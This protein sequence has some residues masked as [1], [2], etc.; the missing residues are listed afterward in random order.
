MK[1]LYI[2]I[3]YPNYRNKIDG[4]I[5]AFSD[6]KCDAYLVSFN[7][8]EQMLCLLEYKDSN[9]VVIEALKK[10]WS[11][12]TYAKYTYTILVKYKFD[13]VYIRRL[14]ISVLLFHK[15]TRLI[16]ANKSKLIYEFPTY[17]L[18]CSDNSIRNLIQSIEKKYVMN[19]IIPNAKCIPICCVRNDVKLKPNM[20]KIYNCA[21]ISFYEGLRE[22]KLPHYDGSQLRILAIAHCQKWHAYE[23]L[24][25]A[26]S[27]WN[28][29]T[30]IT[31]TIYG[32][33][34][35]ETEKL[36]KLTKKYKL[37]NVT[38][39]QEKDVGNYIDFISGF[40][41]AMGCLGIHRKYDGCCD[42]L[43]DTSIKNKEYCAMGLPFVHST[44]DES[45]EDSLDFHFIVKDDESEIDISKLIAWYESIYVK[46]KSRK[47]MMDFAQEHLS[48]DGFAKK[49]L[50]KCTSE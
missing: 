43:L 49:V 32:N 21:D 3:D 30:H 28:N 22:I 40:H 48:Y 29:N 45:F 16:F 14:G 15:V 17:P 26:I 36:L 5:H 23:R 39:L 31:F 8:I 7:P 9:Y 24:I 19:R 12:R 35:D 2:T 6:H 37:Y 46:Y 20:L 42:E 50:E 34:T 13:M 11:R 18:E 47:T 38:F 41:M 1:I 25:T 44:R 10:K 33:F 27:K 4:Q